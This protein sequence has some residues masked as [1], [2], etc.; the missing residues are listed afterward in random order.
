L[1]MLVKIQKVV[2]IVMNVVVVFFSEDVEQ[3]INDPDKIFMSI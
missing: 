3:F 1:K 2:M